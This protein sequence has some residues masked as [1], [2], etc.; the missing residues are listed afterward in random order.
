MTLF[1]NFRERSVAGG[2]KDP[3]FLEGTAQT[4]GG[5]LKV[6]SDGAVIRR[7]SR[8]DVL[9]A[10]HGFNVSMPEGVCS[11][12]RLEEALNL[13]ESC[14]FIGILWPGDFWIPVINY[15]FEGETATDCGRRLARY[16]DRNLRSS[17]SIS[18]I[19]H[20]LGARLAL[21]AAQVLQTK[22]RSICLTAAAVNSDCLTTQYAGAFANSSIISV[23]ASHK[24]LVLKLAFPIGD[25][26]ADLLHSDHAPFRPALGS[27]GPPSA[28]GAT[29]PPWQIPDTAGYNH[30]DYLPP[31]ERAAAFPDAGAKWNRATGFMRRSFLGQA[32]TWPA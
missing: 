30:G 12:G 8:R 11:L 10:T 22:V 15:P 9:F 20:S 6:I 32:Q 26:I 7:T 3:T 4:V 5:G 29:V 19:T 17:S 16:C 14:Q 18:F 27:G 24:D 25:P 2:V 31:S 21:Q 23:L 13:P 1:M 28:V